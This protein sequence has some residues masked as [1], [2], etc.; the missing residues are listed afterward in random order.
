[1]CIFAMVSAMSCST[2]TPLRTPLSVQPAAS[3]PFTAPV[4]YQYSAQPAQSTDSV[5]DLTGRTLSLP[6]CITI[7][8]EQNPGTRSSWQNLQAAVAQ[9]GQA[10]SSLFPEVGASTSLMRADQTAQN[11]TIQGGANL[12][13]AGVSISYVLFDG[14]AR[15]AAI[16]GSEAGMVNA[17][18]QHNTILQDVGLDVAESYYQLL[19]ANQLVR[20]AEQGVQQIQNHVNAAKAR[21]ESGIVNRSDVLRAETDRA[22]AG[23]TLVKALS[24]VRIARGNLANAM[25]AAVTD[26]FSVVELS[27]DIQDQNVGDIRQLMDEALAGRPELQSSLARIEVKRAETKR[28]RSQYWPALTTSIGYGWTD[29][30][31]IPSQNDWS[32]GLKLSI[33]VFDGYNRGYSV[34]R[35]IAELEQSLAEHE[36]LRQGIELEVWNAY[37]RLIEAEQA[38]EAVKILVAS[39]DEAL[40]VAEGEYQNGVSSIILLID[41]QTAQTSASV[42]L[43]QARLDWLVALA[44]IERV[45]GHTLIQESSSQGEAG[46]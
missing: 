32:I 41:A 31:F 24:E 22:D 33:P 12:F 36:Q 4:Q 29:Q 15:S 30:Q 27:D 39:A 2:F 34:Q 19:A 1:M 42:R 7:A 9:A 44:R 25:G 13:D 46:R 45:I 17:G 6:E 10:R 14:G 37:S 40:R 21:Y 5:P 28:A 43:V 26:S 3:I 16:E 38:I 18:F 20:V 11:R 23:L 8:W 35:S